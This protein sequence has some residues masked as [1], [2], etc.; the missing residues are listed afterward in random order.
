MR[1]KRNMEC[2]NQQTI[3]RIVEHISSVFLRNGWWACQI[4]KLGQLRFYLSSQEEK[5]QEWRVDMRM[6]DSEKLHERANKLRERAIELRIRSEILNEESE[7]VIA[8]A[9]ILFNL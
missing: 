9:K 4:E 7:V 3:I 6:K 5:E 1:L 2:I 8:K